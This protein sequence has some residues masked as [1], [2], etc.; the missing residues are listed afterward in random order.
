MS[1]DTVP[2]GTVIPS[3]SVGGVVST[4]VGAIETLSGELLTSV[5]STAGV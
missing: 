5:L 1:T 4:K 3:D 2:L